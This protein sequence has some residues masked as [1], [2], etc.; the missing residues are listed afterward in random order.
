M[1][2]NIN[3][4]SIQCCQDG[5]NND[6]NDDDY[7]MIHWAL[8]CVWHPHVIFFRSHNTIPKVPIPS[9]TVKILKLVHALGRARGLPYVHRRPT[10]CFRCQAGVYGSSPRRILTIALQFSCLVPFS[11]SVR[12]LTQG[13]GQEFHPPACLQLTDRTWLGPHQPCPVRATPLKG[14]HLHCWTWLEMKRTSGAIQPRTAT[15]LS[16]PGQRDKWQATGRVLPTQWLTRARPSQSQPSCQQGRRPKQ[17]MGHLIFLYGLAKWIVSSR[18]AQI[19]VTRMENVSSV[20]L[21]PV[22]GLLAK[23]VNTFTWS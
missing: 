12:R 20:L 13:P 6:K 9:V 2:N 4:K 19:S 18:A 1:Q 17:C 3:N 14:S 22:S 15:P 5:D 7:V 11:A 10:V 16:D 23:S 8:A 21:R